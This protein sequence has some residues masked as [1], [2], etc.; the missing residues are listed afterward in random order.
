[1][2]YQV[3]FLCCMYAVGTTQGVWVP[4]RVSNPTGRLVELS[5]EVGMSVAS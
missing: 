5:R 2:S 3:N 4:G 1:M